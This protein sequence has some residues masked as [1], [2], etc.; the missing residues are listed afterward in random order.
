VQF[1]TFED[2]QV[3]MFIGGG[4]RNA[5]VG[6]M[7]RGCDTALHIDNRGSGCY[8]ISCFPNCPGNCDA[9]TIWDKVGLNN[10]KNGKLLALGPVRKQYTS[11]PWAARFPELGELL[12]VGTLGDPI[13]NVIASN[14]ACGCGAFLPKQYNA[15]VIE[16]RY[17]GVVTNNTVKAKC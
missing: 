7:F 1:N 16:K 6:N 14:S 8:N 12:T 5:V 13:L 15:S 17:L 2:C 11:G 4:R 10:S 9:S 3:G